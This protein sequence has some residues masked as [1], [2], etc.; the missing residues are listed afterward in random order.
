M[1]ESGEPF[2][3]GVVLWGQLFLKKIYLLIF[4]LLVLLRGIRSDPLL[5]LLNHSFFAVGQSF[6]ESW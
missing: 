3:S 2:L 4:G 1:G 6:F 5:G